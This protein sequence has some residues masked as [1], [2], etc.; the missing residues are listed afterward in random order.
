[1]PLADSDGHLFTGRLSLRTHPWLADHAFAGVALVPGTALLDI[2]LQSG[3]RVGCRHVEELTL[4]APLLLPQRGGVVLQISVGAPDGEG[5]GSSPPTRGVTTTS[6]V[7]RTRRAPRVWRARA[8]H[9][10]GMPR[11]R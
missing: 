9:G 3:E 4:H 1:M 10:R 11:A 2:V 5:G 6:R 7:Q 8:I